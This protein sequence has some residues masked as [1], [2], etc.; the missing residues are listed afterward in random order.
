MIRGYAPPTSA[1]SYGLCLRR[2]A[3]KSRSRLFFFARQPAAYAAEHLIRRDKL[4]TFPRWGRQRT[5]VTV[6]LYL[7]LLLTGELARERLRER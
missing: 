2:R 5:R 4:G 6:P 3:K 7:R 1:N